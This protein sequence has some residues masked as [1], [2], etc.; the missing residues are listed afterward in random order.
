MDLSGDER[1]RNRLWTG[2]QLGDECNFIGPLLGN[3]HGVDLQLHEARR[4]GAT[5]GVGYV[6]DL[7]WRPLHDLKLY[8][9]DNLQQVCRSDGRG[10]KLYAGNS[11]T[12]RDQADT[13]GKL[14]T[15]HL[16]S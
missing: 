4:R 5:G 8:A 9:C 10:H 16:V 1:S 13:A 14:V 2:L 11:D 12:N 7:L 15:V 6:E 3:G